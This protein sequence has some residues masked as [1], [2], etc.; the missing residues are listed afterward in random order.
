LFVESAILLTRDFIVL[1][2]S[3]Q[4]FISTDSTNSSHYSI[5]TYLFWYTFSFKFMQRGSVE[6]SSVD[7]ARPGGTCSG[8]AFSRW[9]FTSVKSTIRTGERWVLLK[10]SGSVNKELLLVLPRNERGFWG[11]VTHGKAGFVRLSLPTVAALTPA[12]WNV[13]L[14]DARANPVDYI[15]TVDLV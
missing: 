6:R 1:P 2:I 4:L 7:E 10:R 15:R 5:I 9:Y 14:H 13:T 3:V 12:D 8:H 11:K